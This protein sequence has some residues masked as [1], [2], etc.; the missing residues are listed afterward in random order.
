MRLRLRMVTTAAYPRS[1][2][3]TALF[4]PSCFFSYFLSFPPSAS[5]VHFDAMTR[6]RPAPTSCPKLFAQQE[7]V[8]AARVRE[9]LE[10]HMWGH[11][12][13]KAAKQPR[14]HARH[15]TDAPSTT[16]T[17]SD[18]VSSEEA[19]RAVGDGGPDSLDAAA[20]Q[21]GKEDNLLA[22]LLQVWLCHCVAHAMPCRVA[23]DGGC[24]LSAYLPACLCTCSVKRFTCV[25]CVWL[26]NWPCFSVV[27]FQNLTTIGN[28]VGFA[29]Q[30][31]DSLHSFCPHPL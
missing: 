19:V 21:E 26:H 9:A 22:S 7:A 29:S 11:L 20:T 5:H 27:L 2:R 25:L 18:S 10:A 1:P 17:C 28:E 23:C 14:Q 30:L 3:A 4:V 24:F 12:E 31:L 8:G 6:C 16:T 15:D 13:M